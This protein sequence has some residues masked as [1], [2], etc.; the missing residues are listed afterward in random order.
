MDIVIHSSI[1]FNNQWYSKFR[2][3]LS[4]SNLKSLFLK[5]VLIKNIL[6]IGDGIKLRVKDIVI[7]KIPIIIIS[8]NR[9]EVLK[10][11]INSFYQ[12]IN[13]DFE[14]VIFDNNTSFQP[15]LAY[16]GELEKNGI[17][18]VYNKLKSEKDAGFYDISEKLRPLI[19]RVIKKFNSDYFVVTDPDIALDKSDGNILEFYKYLLELF[20]K[21]PVVGP[22][23]RIDDLPDC[24]PLKEKVIEL[25]HR[26]FWAR[27]RV[28]ILFKQQK[29]YFQVSSIDTTFGL[30]R[31]DFEFKKQNYALRT[32]EP[33]TARHLDWYLDP[34]NLRED[35]IYYM[36]NS[37][38]VLASWGAKFLK[39]YLNC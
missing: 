5:I 28:P 21:I 1:V 15:T 29:L 11:S 35:Q 17:L 13:S 12:N 38:V 27:E 8:C 4:V 32:Y 39:K 10:E 3:K 16:L 26:R 33:Y 23:L 36:K 2:Q 37:S 20:P 30:Y 18:V 31:K 14:I 34:S 25:H 6:Y 9:L 19:Q 22:M 24:Y 7:N